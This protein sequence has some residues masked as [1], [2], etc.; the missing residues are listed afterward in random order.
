M[1]LSYL[2]ERVSALPPKSGKL[3]CMKM[4][5]SP[6]FFATWV[7]THFGAFPRA[8]GKREQHC[9]KDNRLPRLRA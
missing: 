9:I 2:Y 4:K 3:T 1:V 5:R 7:T 6:C 8:G